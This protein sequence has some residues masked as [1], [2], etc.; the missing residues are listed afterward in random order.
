MPLPGLKQSVCCAEF[1][2][3]VRALEE[4]QPYE[5][6][7]CKRSYQDFAMKVYHFWTPVLPQLR[8]RPEEQRR[9]KLPI[10]PPVPPPAAP[11]RVSDTDAP[12]QLGKH[13]RVVKHANF[14]QCLDCNRKA[15]KVKV[16]KPLANTTLPT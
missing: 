12:F 5:Q 6:R 11:A 15:G 2:A 10:D 1:I 4:C 3:V 13:Q 9:V 8:E 7:S 14:L 16:T